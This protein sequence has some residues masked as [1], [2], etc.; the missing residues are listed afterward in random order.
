[1]WFG[2]RVDVD[3]VFG[4]FRQRWRDL[5]AKSRQRRL[6]S[7]PA[8]SAALDDYIEELGTL[9]DQ[10][11]KYGREAEELRIEVTLAVRNEVLKMRKRSGLPDEDPKG[12]LAETWRA[13]GSQGKVEGEMKDQSVVKDM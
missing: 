5:K 3:A 7:S 9:H 6:D 11:L 12:S 2:E 1:M 8:G 10:D 4:P 13:E